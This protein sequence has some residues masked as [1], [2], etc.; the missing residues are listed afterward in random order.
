[1]SPSRLRCCAVRHRRSG[2]CTQS[3]AHAPPPWRHT[4]TAVWQGMLFRGRP[5]AARRTCGDNLRLVLHTERPL[6]RDLGGGV[7]G[8]LHAPG[9]EMRPRLAWASGEMADGRRT[10]SVLGGKVSSFNF[11]LSRHENCVTQKTNADSGFSFCARTLCESPDGPRLRPP[12]R[13][14]AVC[15]RAGAPCS[16]PR[17]HEQRPTRLAT[18]EGAATEL[19]GKRGLPRELEEDGHQ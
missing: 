16:P 14:P 19:G 1:M 5:G 2:R 3:P 9:S 11:S 18:R 7:G 4:Q 17:Q 12:V 8:I 10:L 13:C 15:R 6:E